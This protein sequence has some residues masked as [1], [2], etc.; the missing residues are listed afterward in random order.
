MAT[1]HRSGNTRDACG[2]RT[3][4]LA[5]LLLLFVSLV[6]PAHAQVAVSA[7]VSNASPAVGEPLQLQLR[8][9]GTSRAGQPPEVSVDGLDIRYLGPSTQMS[10]I[11]GA[12][13]SSVTHVYQVVPMRAGTF[14]I[15][16]IE[17]ELE[18][19]R[20]RTAPVALT[21]RAG[22]APPAPS[23]VPPMEKIAFAEITVPKK[24]AY[25]GEAIPAEIRL[26]VDG[27]VQSQIETIPQIQG[28]GFTKTKLSEPRREVARRDGREYN[29]VVFRT[30]ITP[31]K[32]GKISIGPAD[33]SFIAQIPRAQRT[34]QRSLF[35]MFDDVFS[36]GFGAAQ[37]MTARAEAV[38]LDVKPLPVQGR[39]ADFAGAVGDFRLMAEGS[40]AQVKVGDPVTMRLRVS[41]RGNFDR[42]AAPTIV[43]AA[44]WRSYPPSASFAAEDELAISGV[45]TFEMAV[46]PETA[47][48]AM[49]AYAF[50]YFDPVA[51][52]YVT[53]KSEPA[54][55]LVQGAPPPPPPVPQAAPSTAGD[56]PEPPV[57]PAPAAQ[58]I[59]GVHYELGDPR[60]DFEP[61]Y[62]RRSFLLAQL[63]PLAILL[64]LIGRRLLHRDE[65][66]RER[67]GMLREK[68]TLRRKLRSES[69]HA[70][71][72]D[73]AARLVQ[74][75][76]AL[77]T[78]RLPGSVDAAVACASRR[79]DAETAAAV[80][81]IFNARAELLYAGGHGGDG[82]L[83]Q[84]DR[85][86][87]L[88]AIEKFSAA[89]GKA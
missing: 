66:Q 80:A 69:V 4:L 9:T 70:E 60:R 89:H 15:P 46:I 29:V 30:A 78:G 18:G 51:A 41:G 43:D 21:V 6:A 79:L 7:S 22:H 59:L 75:E 19:R 73:V 86:R 77:R 76:T 74:I 72:F 50:S 33:F 40:P 2:A 3:P 14:T 71:F 42:V 57:A 37:R 24:T 34:R 63:V 12:M 23:G 25:V 67:E 38:E 83:A 16:P 27:T 62:A 11:N 55:L 10:I 47:K 56:E 58:D 68:E 87:V 88:A 48:T 13:S 20:L 31:G 84:T 45:K 54:P 64:A 81:E 49:P 39:P 26:F 52:K 8:C 44:G 28:E 17:I 36:N 65:G 53:L 85:D 35:D 61:L 5:L 1:L 32:A 82:H